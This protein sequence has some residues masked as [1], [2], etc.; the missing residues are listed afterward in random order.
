[1][2]TR[3][4][5]CHIWSKDGY[6]TIQTAEHAHCFENSALVSRK[7]QQLEQVMTSTQ[8]KSTNKGKSEKAERLYYTQI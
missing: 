6:E 4:A 2:G 8:N 7:T 3:Q 5:L 1:M